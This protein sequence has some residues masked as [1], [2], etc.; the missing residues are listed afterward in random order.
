MDGTDFRPQTAGA[1]ERVVCNTLWIGP[2]LGRVERA[3]LRSFLRNGHPVTL[4]CYDEVAGV[5]EGV[6]LADA[7]EVLP[8]E[9]VRSWLD[10]IRQA[11]R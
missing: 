2:E 9:Q 7:H 11:P 1:G 10:R 5:P 6:V 3:C 8:A 4:Y